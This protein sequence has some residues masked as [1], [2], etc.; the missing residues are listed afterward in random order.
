MA[1]SEGYRGLRVVADMDWLRGPGARHSRDR[2]FRA[3]SRPRRT[4]AWR[5]DRLRISPVLV[6]HRRDR[7]SAG[8]PPRGRR[9]RGAAPVP[10]GRRRCLALEARRGDRLLLLQRVPG[11]L[12]C[13]RDVRRVHGGRQRARVHRRS[14]H[15]R[16]GGRLRRHRQADRVGGR[17]AHAPTALG[18]PRPRSARAGNPAR[19]LAGISP[20]RRCFPSPE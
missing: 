4:R 3:R 8:G 13:S 7:R 14:R 16:H 2:R 11:R 12:R 10:A 17:L 1:L 15:T 9:R 5:H 20:R 19:R 18:H 6:R